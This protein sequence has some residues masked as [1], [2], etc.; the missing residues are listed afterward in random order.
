MTQKQID[1]AKKTLPLRLGTPWK[2]WT[3]EQRRLSNELSC[4]EMIN[5]CLT[6]GGIKEFWR[7]DPW[8]WGD[9]KSYAAPHVR[10]LGIERVK[11]LI[12]EQEA[13]FAKARVLSGVGT[14]GEGGIYNTVIWHDEAC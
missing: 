9:D 14:D 11:Q 5:S 1:A 8:R 4:R 2:D 7:E 10:N 13:D 6:Y 3:P 12:A